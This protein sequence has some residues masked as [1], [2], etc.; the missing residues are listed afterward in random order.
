MLALIAPLAQGGVEAV[1]DQTTLHPIGLAAIVV[2]GVAVLSVPRRH[3]VVPFLMMA[4]LLAPAQRIVVAG[5]D[6]NLVRILVMFGWARMLMRGE[7]RMRWQ[8]IDTLLVAW[9]STSALAFMLLH[10]SAG[11]V[12]NRLG[13]LYDFIGMYVYFRCMVRSWQDFDRILNALSAIALVSLVFFVIESRTQRNMFSVLGGVPAITDVR[14]GRLRCQGP[15][16]HPILAGCFWA[17]CLPLVAARWWTHR[18]RRGR[19][20]V[21]SAAIVG[22]VVTTASST[23]LMGLAAALLGLAMFPLRR[24]M[25]A[26]RWTLIGG[27][28]LLHMVMTGPVW[29]LIMRIDLVGGSSGYHRYLLID[30]T[31]RRAGEWWL[32]GVKST[33]HWGYYMRDTANQYVAE[34]V[35]GGLAGLVL[36]LCT[37]GTGFLLVG[38]MRVWVGR[39]RRSQIPP[40]SLGVSLFTHALMFIGI[41]ISYAH[42]NLM[43]LV[44]VLASIA[45][46]SIATRRMAAR[47]RVTRIAAAREGARVHALRPA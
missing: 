15:F 47:T 41:S 4:C 16:P 17:G 36:F 23:P 43:L 22:I 38:R 34:A 33:V 3:A 35:S 39:R 46:L 9:V 21:A 42:Q 32:I 5:L 24:H 18:R 14:E 8:R 2:L 30:Q 40:W 31:I 28:V 27:L 44:L 45:S 10:G 13:R 37:L 6:F 19:T 12:T 20:L 26:V 11:A 1:Y 29:S 25:K 7:L